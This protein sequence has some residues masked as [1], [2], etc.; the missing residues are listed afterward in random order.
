[1]SV[2]VFL[3]WF[4]LWV[5]A[6]WSSKHRTLYVCPLPCVVVAFQFGDAHEHDV[7]VEW[8]LVKRLRAENA[9]LVAE[10]AALREQTR[11]RPIIER[12]GDPQE[13][14]LVGW[15]DLDD[16]AAAY[17]DID[18]RWREAYTMEFLSSEPDAFR[19]LP[20]PPEQP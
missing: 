17:Q 8:T 2:R 11:W 15:Y 14:A 4:D 3:A 18:G 6:Y 9:A 16:I 1:M 12:T 5:G 20:V 7:E 13:G 10:L 19:S